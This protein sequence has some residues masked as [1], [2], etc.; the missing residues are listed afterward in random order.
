MS[1]VTVLFCV[2]EFDGSNHIE[3]SCLLNTEWKTDTASTCCLWTSWIPVYLFIHFSVYILCHT[4][5]CIQCALLHNTIL[6]GNKFIYLYRFM[7]VFSI[8]EEICV[9]SMPSG[10]IVVDGNWQYAHVIFHPDIGQGFGNNLQNYIYVC[11]QPCHGW[12]L[13]RIILLRVLNF[14]VFFISSSYSFY[15]GK[16]MLF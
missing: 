6:S 1:L 16:P 13:F 10:W 8:R 9:G 4:V 3:H 2:D 14:P 11:I 15:R 5:Q 7:S 12:R